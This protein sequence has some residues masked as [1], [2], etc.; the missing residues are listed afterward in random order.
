M[1][2]GTLV[3]TPANGVGVVIDM[4][5]KWSK[6]LYLLHYANGTKHWWSADNLEVLCK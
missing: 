6:K 2:V 1:Q 5:Y 4:S 3:N